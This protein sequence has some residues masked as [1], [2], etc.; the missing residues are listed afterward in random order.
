M[1]WEK[2]GTSCGDPDPEP[3][4]HVLGLPDTDPLFK[5]KDLDPAPDPVPDFSLF[6]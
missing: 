2:V 3:H 5:G 6:S 1:P 4:P